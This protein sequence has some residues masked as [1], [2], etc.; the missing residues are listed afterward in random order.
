M[1]RKFI[2]F[3]ILSLSVGVG[4]IH[5]GRPIA[6]SQDTPYIQAGVIETIRDKDYLTVL[7]DTT[8]DKDMYYIYSGDKIIGNISSLKEIPEISS[9]KRY[10]CN[11]S[12]LKDEFRKILRPGLDIVIVLIDKEIDK[13]LRKNIYTDSPS[14]KT[15]II[16]PIDK[17][18]M[19]L[20]PEGDFFMGCSYCN[21]D[22]FPEHRE[23]LGDYYIDKFEVSNNDY[24]VFADIKGRDYPE[25]WKDQ[26]DK[27]NNF[28][29]LYFASLPVIVTY[30][31]AEDYA[32]WAGK[33]LPSEIE[34][35]KAARFPEAKEKT[36]QRTLY[37]WGNKFKDGIS[38]TEEFWS[39]D[40]VGQNLKKKIMEK[41]GLAKTEKGYIPVEMYEKEA[42]SYYGVANLDGNALEWTNSWYKGYS[43]SDKISNKYGEQY[44]VIKGGSYF[45]SKNDARI[46]SRK[47]GGSP[48]L[49]KDRIAG[50][51]CVKSVSESDKE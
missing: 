46:T 50:F 24:K 44:K 47:I 28:L 39:S 23:F 32:S 1:L 25:Y 31:E 17:R 27:K 26:M 16:S 5:L 36:G 20:I 29:N 6:Y 51:R 7:F 9:K 2:F 22:E 42:L 3:I 30:Y 35:E 45:L 13:E 10:L 48:N 21:D 40:K 12:L 11:Y 34:W 41:Y 43:E 8:P 49:Y 14:Y 15:E 4:V 19:V 18:E 38:N 33:R 37:S